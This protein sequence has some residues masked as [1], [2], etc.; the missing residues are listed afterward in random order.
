MSAKKVQVKQQAGNKG[1]FIALAAIAVAGAGYMGWKSQQPRVV[2]PLVLP[3]VADSAL[4]AQAHGYTL[5]D[6]SAKVELSEFADFECPAC[7]RFY[8]ITEPDIKK[9]LV[10]T[11]LV[12]YTFYD[13]PLLNAHQNTVVASMAAACSDDQSKFWEM[14]DQLFANQNAWSGISTGN[15]RGVITAYAQRIGLDIGKWNACMDASTH[16]DRIKANYAKGLMQQV[17]GTPSFYVNGV[18]VDSRN[19]VAT[20]DEIKAAV[21]AALAAAAPTAA[22]A[23]T[24]PAKPRD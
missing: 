9:N 15:P 14:H 23:A 5:G 24:T 21:D 11:G 13:F 18:R 20:Y 3:T 8:D 2:A 4:A 22:P 1:F 10:A 16:A 19:G 7:A 17:T 6:A 12:R